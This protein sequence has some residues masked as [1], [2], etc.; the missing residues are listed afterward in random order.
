MQSFNLPLGEDAPFTSSGTVK[1]RRDV[2]RPLLKWFEE[3]G[4][5]SDDNFDRVV[6]ELNCL[7]R[8]LLRQSHATETSASKRK[9]SARLTTVPSAAA[10]AVSN[11]TE[12]N[13]Q[14]YHADDFGNTWPAVTN[15]RQAKFASSKGTAVADTIDDK[16]LTALGSTSPAP[17]QE[18]APSP[19]PAEELQEF[20]HYSCLDKNPRISVER[21]L[22]GHYAIEGLKMHEDYEEVLAPNGRLATKL[23]GQYILYRWPHEL[24]QKKYQDDGWFVGQVKSLC[25]RRDIED[26][27]DPHGYNHPNFNVDFGDTGGPVHVLLLEERLL[28]I[29]PR[30]KPPPGHWFLLQRKDLHQPD[31]KAPYPP[32][33]R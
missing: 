21:A 24:H 18:P 25:T 3:F 31:V 7:Q 22:S 30:P 11:S 19:V 20:P 13:N 29:C 2:L 23:L 8:L 1:E 12:P 32:Q 9:K 28:N 14:I 26:H 17:Q 6:D 4:E 10:S 16:S 33:K 5:T 15:R 27:S